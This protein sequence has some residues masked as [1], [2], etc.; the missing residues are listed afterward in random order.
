ME[1]RRRRKKAAVA[2]PSD[3]DM[4][5]SERKRLVQEMAAL[6]D[7]YQ[8]GDIQE[9]EYMLQREEMKRSG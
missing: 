3:V 2:V 6:D 7:S 4:A 5:G 8:A 9:D 1:M